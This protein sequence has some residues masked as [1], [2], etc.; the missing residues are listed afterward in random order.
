V[1]KVGRPSL[2]VEQSQAAGDV[3]MSIIRGNKTTMQIAKDLKKSHPAIIHELKALLAKDWIKRDGKHYSINREKTIDFACKKFD[4]D[5]KVVEPQFDGLIGL[6][7]ASRQK[8]TIESLG[9][10]LNFQEK[11]HI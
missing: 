10:Y 7:A 8:A 5:R 9:L 1:N 3:F 11:K 2:K 6:L 4:L